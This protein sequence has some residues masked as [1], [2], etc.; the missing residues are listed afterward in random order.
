MGSTK[1]RSVTNGERGRRFRE[2]VTG[3]YA[4]QGVSAMAET[5][6]DAATPMGRKIT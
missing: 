4:E 3:R 5:A 1:I 2:R 6:A